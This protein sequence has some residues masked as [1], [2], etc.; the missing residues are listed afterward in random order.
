MRSLPYNKVEKMREIDS[1]DTVDESTHSIADACDCVK[2]LMR[3]RSGR[4]SRSRGQLL[5]R[6][7]RYERGMIAD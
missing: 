5:I 4:Q 6:A 3:K 2:I 1:P 7:S